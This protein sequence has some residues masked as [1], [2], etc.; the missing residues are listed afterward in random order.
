[1]FTIWN[2]FNSNRRARIHPEIFFRTKTLSTRHEGE[3]Q[4][5][6]LCNFVLFLAL[7]EAAFFLTFTQKIFFTPRHEAHEGEMQFSSLCNFV[8]LVTGCFPSP[9]LLG[10]VGVRFSKNLFLFPWSSCL[11]C[12]TL[13]F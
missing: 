1:M 11:I 8:L 12:R 9:S 6:S 3:M 13:P 5:S 7:C 4:I 2:S 10:R